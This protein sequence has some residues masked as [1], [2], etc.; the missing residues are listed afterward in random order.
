MADV[1]TKPANVSH[2]RIELGIT[3]ARPPE[4]EENS[5]GLLGC[6]DQNVGI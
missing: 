5:K 1:T 4:F 2:F 6:Q 3:I